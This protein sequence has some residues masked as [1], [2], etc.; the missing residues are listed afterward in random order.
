MAGNCGTESQMAKMSFEGIPIIAAVEFKL[1]LEAYFM[2]R[3]YCR[4]RSNLGLKTGPILKVAAATWTQ[5]VRV[6]I[7]PILFLPLLKK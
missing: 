4:T 5:P 2:D 7:C 3:C 1:L 6:Q